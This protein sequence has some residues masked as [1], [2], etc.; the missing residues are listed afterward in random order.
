V[1]AMPQLLTWTFPQTVGGGSLKFHLNWVNNN[2]RLIDGWLWFW[3]KN[4]GPVFL[5]FV[6]GALSSDRRGRALAAGALTVFALAETILFQPNPYDNNKL[7]YV[8]FIL[9]L[10]AASKYVVTVYDRLRGVKWRGVL[11]AVFLVVSTLSASVTLAREAISDYT[12]F[13]ADEAGA[14]QFIEEFA[15]ADAVVLTGG[16]HNNPVA[17]LAGRKLVCGTGTYLYYHGVNYQRQ[18]EAARAMYENPGES[19]VLFDVYKVDYAYVSSYERVDYDIDEDF[20]MENFPVAY[21]NSE[22]T[23]YAVSPRAVA[24]VKSRGASESGN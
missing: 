9:M 23:V 21:K 8:A 15:P 16:Q 6:P 1:L 4:V 2:G 18:Q 19:A 11:L 20:F 22:V 3:V 17:A 7:F 5:L 10:P 14:A 12:L 24:A 13:S